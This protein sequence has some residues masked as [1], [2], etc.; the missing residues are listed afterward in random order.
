MLENL[1]DL[2]DYELQEIKKDY[3]KKINSI[4]IK[5]KKLEV[6][7]KS[8]TVFYQLIDKIIQDRYKNKKRNE[9]IH[10]MKE[11]G[12][13]EE[14]KSIPYFEDYYNYFVED[15]NVY[16]ELYLQYQY[17]IQSTIYIS[18]LVKEEFKKGHD[19]HDLKG[20][21]DIAI[22]NIDQF[23]WN[24]CCSERPDYNDED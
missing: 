2:K 19:F 3:S 10:E 16:T 1:E 14:E 9:F 12:L 5:L 13:T 21:I 6:E 23:L 18:D 22:H 7:K 11:N 8:F 24:K 17:D 4:N 15:D 20:L